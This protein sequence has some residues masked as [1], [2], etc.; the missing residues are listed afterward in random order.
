MKAIAIN[1]SPRPGGN[2]EIMLKR[3]TPW[4]TQAR[5]RSTCG[6]AEDRYGIFLHGTFPVQFCMCH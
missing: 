3:M 4:K 6:L 5:A 1:S 2:T